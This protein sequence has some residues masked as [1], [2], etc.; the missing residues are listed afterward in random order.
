MLPYLVTHY[1]FVHVV[2][3]TCVWGISQQEHIYW[4][5]SLSCPD[6][7]FI[8]HHS[9]TFVFLTSLIMCSPPSFI[10]HRPTSSFPQLSSHSLMLRYSLSYHTHSPVL[11]P[12]CPSLFIQLGNTYELSSHSLT[13]NLFIRLGL[14]T[15][16]YSKI[17]RA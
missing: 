5:C 2:V 15:S 4:T 13:L 10:Y 6:L 7:S 16:K 1:L 8:P 12:I 17:W 3:Y 14:T 11:I 9:Y